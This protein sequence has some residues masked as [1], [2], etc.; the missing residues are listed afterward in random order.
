[1][2]AIESQIFPHLP[3]AYSLLHPEPTCRPVG[4]SGLPALIA[5][6]WLVV[7][8]QEGDDWWMINHAQGAT[9]SNYSEA[10]IQDVLK[11]FEGDDPARHLWR[12][13]S[14]GNYRLLI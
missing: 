11:Q 12:R 8:I 2:N 3:E 13:D 14:N 5:V 4:F 10:E 1:M 7:I 9:G 6:L